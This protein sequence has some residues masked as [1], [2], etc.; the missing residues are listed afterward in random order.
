LALVGFVLEP[1]RAVPVAS[2]LAAAAIFV[3]LPMIMASATSQMVGV[4]LVVVVPISFALL[5]GTVQGKRFSEGDSELLD[6]AINSLVLPAGATLL[7][8]IVGLLFWLA[9]DRT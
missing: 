2:I 8:S 5:V 1:T 7:A 6:L 9:G 4:I 3:L